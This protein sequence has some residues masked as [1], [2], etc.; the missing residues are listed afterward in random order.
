MA[1]IEELKQQ[2][3]AEHSAGSVHAQIDEV[4][5]KRTKDQKPYLEIL[6]RDGTASFP[7]R[8]WSDHPSFGFCSELRSGHFVEV[9]GDFIV[10]PTFGLEV[11]N[12]NLRFLT[13]AEQ[14]DLLAGP[15]DLREKQCI[16]YSAIE[17][18][19]A[20]LRDPR[21]RELSLL[22]LHDFGDRLR[23]AAGARRTIITPGAADW[24]NTLRK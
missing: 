24:L 10:S 20:S 13:T 1:T 2:T 14:T 17:S 21:L 4:I 7:L 9:Q 23:R 3:V 16:D 19:T 11:R 5:T 15:P 8:V 18:F 6:L 22:F 12:W